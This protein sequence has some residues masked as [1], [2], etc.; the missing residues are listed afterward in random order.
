VATTRYPAFANSIDVRS[1]NPLEHPV[2]RAILSAIEMVY[3]KPQARSPAQ[4]SN[5]AISAAFSAMSA[6]RRKARTAEIAE[7]HRRG[8]RESLGLK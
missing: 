2:M 4:S 1:P 7:G 8:R 5:A 3:H 6:V